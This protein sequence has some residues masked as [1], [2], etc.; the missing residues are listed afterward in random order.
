MPQ[1]SD[2][3]VDADLSTQGAPPPASR[4]TYTWREGLAF[5]AAINIVS[6]LLGT[7][8]GR[9]EAIKRPWFAPPGWVFPVAWG[10]NN[11]LAIRGNLRVLNAPPST[12]RTAYLRLWAATWILYVLFGYAFFGRKSPLLGMLDTVNFLALAGLAAG[13][14]VLIDRGLWVTYATLLPWLTL[15]T[16]VAVAVALQNPDPLLDPPDPNAP[17]SNAP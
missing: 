8:T 1:P 10:I 9:Y 7:N 14:A 12:D 3:Q 13:R 5:G 4:R 11:V 17:G 16:A 6:R 15:A 2:L